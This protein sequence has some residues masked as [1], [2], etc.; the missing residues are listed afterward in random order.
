MLGLLLRV[1]LLLL[2]F[3]LVRLPLVKPIPAVVVILKWSGGWDDGRG[4]YDRGRR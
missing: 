3:G 4:F 2:R 1:V